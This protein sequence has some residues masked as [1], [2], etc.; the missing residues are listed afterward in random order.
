MDPWRPAGDASSKNVPGGNPAMRPD[1]RLQPITRAG[2]GPA[3]QSQ[4]F[5]GHLVIIFGSGPGTGFFLYN[6][7]P[8]PGN[9]PIL[10][11][12]SASTDPYG[13]PV[14]ANTINAPTL[15]LIIGAITALRETLNPGPLLLYGS[16]TTVVDVRNASGT[17]VAPAGVTSVQVFATG[18][19]GSGSTTVTGS[20]G[21]GGG[22]GGEEAND[23]A[24]VT[25]GNSYPFTIGTGGTGTDTTFTG[26]ALT[27]TAH[28]GL[29]A[30]STTI[31]AAG[32]SGSTN[33]HHFN[34]GTGGNGRVSPAVNGGGGGG[35]AGPGSV[36]GTGG[37]PAGGSGGAG[38]GVI[39]A[40]GNG[41]AG[42]GTGGTG[43]SN[44]ANGTAPGGGGGGAIT[45]PGVAGTGAPGQI[46]FVYTASGGTTALAAA[47]ASGAANDGTNSWNAG[48]GLLKTVYSL[49]G[50]P[51]APEIWHVVGA[52]S[53][54]AFQNSFTAGGTTPRFQLEPVGS[55]GRVRLSGAV[56]TGASNVAEAVIFNLPAGYRPA[57]A[58]SFVT[59]TNITAYVLGEA[60]VD[61]TT[62]GDV[63][64]NPVSTT[65]KFLLLDG[66]CFELD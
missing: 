3:P 21:G 29:N 36:G 39:G 10:S 7:S 44:G 15:P 35:A 13:N 57:R 32:G 45:T 63:R 59:P 24:A 50:T 54:P 46:I 20:P 9:P 4:T 43:T 62:G 53:Q 60:S 38:S 18:E 34:G 22:G 33:A 5:I 30:V 51:E 6:G 1:Q 55:G 41:G 58:F 40:G 56:N 64:C 2:S 49:V 66:I 31:G 26:D 27:V 25:P 23:T 48:L 52:A 17:F 11:I 14:P 37:T 47:L 16:T 65:G 19:G 61:I 8:G 12:T 28:H 42:A